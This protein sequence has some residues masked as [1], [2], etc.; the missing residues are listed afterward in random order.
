M[1][2][3]S[4][5]FNSWAARA[6]PVSAPAGV[7]AYNFNIAEAAS[8][9]EIEVVGS[10][11]FDRGNTDWACE[12]RWTSR[13][14]KYVA[15]YAD[16][17]RDWKPFLAWVA[18]VVRAYIESGLPGAETLKQAQAVT[19]GFVDGELVIVTGRDV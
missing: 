2:S 1:S 9:F 16:A 7:L 13:P 14:L 3:A 5:S 19:A 18:G 8:G 15:P 11:Y 12:E 4:D 17:G 6:L 10:S